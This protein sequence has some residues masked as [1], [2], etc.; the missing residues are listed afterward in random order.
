[1]RQIDPDVVPVYPITPQTPIIQT[2]AKFV[3]DGRAQHGDRERRVRALCD[4]RGDRRCARRR[5]DDDGDVVAGAG[6]DGRDRLHRR[7]DARADRDGG[8]QPR[9]LG[10][11]Q[12][13]LRPL[14]LDAGPRLRRRPALRRERPGGL[15]PD[16]AG[17]AHRRAPRCAAAGA[18]LPGRLHDHPLGRAGG[19]P[20]GRR[21]SARSSASTASRTR[22]RH[23][24]SRRR[25]G[26]S[27]CP[28]TTSS[29]AASR[30]PRSRP[31][32]TSSPRS[33]AEFALLTGRRLGALEEYRLDGADAR[34]RRARLDRRHDQGRH[35]RAARRRRAGRAAEARLVPALPRAAVAAAL[36]AS[37]S[38]AVLDRADSPGGTP[39]LHA[40]LAAAL[41]GSGVELDGPSTA[42]AAATCIRRTSARSSPG[43]AP[44]TSACE[45][46]RCPV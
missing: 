36:A 39:P 24:R 44:P 8:R 27:R 6:I 26:R 33:A 28:T 25:R 7:L 18:R 29:C 14:G 16:G 3:A 38:V 2:F 9:A 10:A 4:E 23:R 13:P 41:Y 19:A 12:H 40:E 5:A 42:S 15:R 32:S 11:D 22:A 37:E 43:R 21:A 35:R 45:V 46:S 30:R 1:M 31:R 20:A 34:D 17:A